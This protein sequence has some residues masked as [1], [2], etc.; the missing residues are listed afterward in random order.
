VTLVALATE[1]EQTAEQFRRDKP[2]LGKEGR[3]YRFN[4][5]QRLEDVSLEESKKKKEIAAATDRYIILQDV[6]E[7]DEVMCE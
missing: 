1:T 4:V 3:Y 2:S 7:T 5:L 6:F